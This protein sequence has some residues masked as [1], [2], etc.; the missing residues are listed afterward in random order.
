MTDTD[1]DGIYE[2]T[3]VIPEN[4][5]ISYKYLNGNVFATQEDVPAACGVDNG[6]GGY[7]RIM[8]VGSVDTTLGVVC[9]GSC[10]DCLPQT[11]VVLTLQVDMSNQVVTNDEVYIAGSF[12]NWS[13]TESLMIPLG[14]GIYQ[15]PIVVIA[16][17][18]VSYKFI[19]GTTW[20]TVSMECGTSDGFGGYNRSFTAP[21]ANE[22]FA[23]VC[24]NECAAC[25]VEPVVMLTL[26]VNMTDVILNAT[27]VYVAGTFN[28]FSP[29]AT[30]MEQVSNG[31]YS[32]TL[33]VGQNQQILYKFLNGNDF[34]GVESV[35]FECGVNDGFGGYNRSI[36]T[37]A[38]DITLPTVCFSSCSDCVLSVNEEESLSVNVYP[39]PA[40]E[41]VTVTARESIQSLDVYDAYGRIVYTQTNLGNVHTIDI[42][43]LAKGI[44]HLLL[45]GEVSQ[46]L[47]VE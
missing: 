37:N 1:S 29:T 35:P 26:T 33:E 16:G 23:P 20:E 47:I 13:A 27:G 3:A 17:E 2:F 9:F 22:E 40:R 41:F 36:T 14:D 19:N 38:S 46:R 45:N 18:E 6:F 34:A 24:F 10:A 39:N 32:V 12:N 43:R 25:V 42:S 44:Y 4:T 31:I 21:S 8:Q 30:M 5:E 11:F 15:L 7:D 28:N